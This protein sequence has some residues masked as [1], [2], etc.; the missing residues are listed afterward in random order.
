MP[1]IPNATDPARLIQEMKPRSAAHARPL[2]TRKQTHPNTSGAQIRRFSWLVE[3]L[4]SSAEPVLMLKNTVPASWTTA[5]HQ[6]SRG[7]ARLSRYCTVAAEV[8]K[9]EPMKN[10]AASAVGPTSWRKPGNG[11]TAKQD[12]PM[13]NSTPLHHVLLRCRGVAG[14]AI[15]AIEPDRPWPGLTRRG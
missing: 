5:A 10:T 1:A 6:T 4:S 12:E 7:P 8:K 2:A 15:G 3:R 9:I 11:P 14:S 13:M